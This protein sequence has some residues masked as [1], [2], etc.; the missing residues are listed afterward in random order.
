MRG[1]RGGAIGNTPETVFRLLSFTVREVRAHPVSIS[2]K[3]KKHR[4]KSQEME[5][6]VFGGRGNDTHT[7]S[8]GMSSSASQT[9]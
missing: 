7:F 6:R 1:A 2:T 4:L 8:W 9:D 5:L 3:S